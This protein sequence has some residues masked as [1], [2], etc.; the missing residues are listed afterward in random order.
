MNG[1]DNHDHERHVLKKQVDDLRTALAIAQV[2]MLFSAIVAL[3]AGY[4]LRGGCP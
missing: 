3:F 2:G 4:M 1:P